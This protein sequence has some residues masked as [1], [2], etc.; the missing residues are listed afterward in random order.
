MGLK[1]RVR[2]VLYSVGLKESGIGSKGVPDWLAKIQE[3]MNEYC[4]ASGAVFNQ[5]ALNVAEILKQAPKPTVRKRSEAAMASPPAIHKPAPVAKP[6]IKTTVSTSSL[7]SSA[8]CLSTE[9]M[10]LVLS[11]DPVV[12]PFSRQSTLQRMRGDGDSFKVKD[13][14]TTKQAIS[15]LLP[16]T[17]LRLDY[18]RTDA[19]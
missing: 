16:S 3:D 9:E 7:S 10:Y 2:R 8:E 15:V 14:E 18:T 19:I 11:N 1:G 12:E 4:E 6:R 13:N 17:A 5:A